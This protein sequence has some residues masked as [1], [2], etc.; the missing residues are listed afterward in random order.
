MMPLMPKLV[1]ARGARRA[2]GVTNKMPVRYFVN[3]YHKISTLLL[4]CFNQQKSLVVNTRTCVLWCQ[5]ASSQQI[6]LPTVGRTKRYC[7]SIVRYGLEHVAQSLVGTDELVEMFNL[8]DRFDGLATSF[9]KK[10][11]F[12][13]CAFDNRG[14][15]R[16]SAPPGPY[17]TDMMA[18]DALLLMDDI[19]F[20]RAHIVGVSMGGM[21]SQKI[22]LQAP[23]RVLSLTLIA[24]RGV[25]GIV[26]QRP[27]LAGLGKFLSVAVE[28]D[29]SKHVTKVMSLMFSDEYL[30]AKADDASPTNRE[31]IADEFHKVMRE[32]PG[33]ER[34]GELHQTRA[35][36]AHGLTDA[37]FARIRSAVFP[38]LIIHGRD[39]ILVRFVHGEELHRKIG[40]EFLPVDN[41]GHGVTVQ[42][43]ELVRKRS[44]AVVVSVR[45]G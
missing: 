38:K 2:H 27:T 18:T 5:I 19:G 16:S 9:S 33:N 17:S 22:A 7:E 45:A 43:R 1:S 39:D 8:R 26:N 20:E 35:V 42:A 34:H 3:E 28:K 10:L 11:D 25:G 14:A 31:L 21:I 23:E 41:A 36:L 12:H 13:V 44:Y 37:E 6:I 30:N 15:H 29:V 40:G 24:T 4:V 32:E